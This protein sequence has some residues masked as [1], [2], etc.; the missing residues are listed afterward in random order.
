MIS[1]SDQMLRAIGQLRRR[2]NDTNE[3]SPTFSDEQ[4]YGYI[5][6]AVDHLELTSF[7]KGRAVEDG[8]FVSGTSLLPVTVPRPEQFLY[9]LQAAILVTMGIKSKADRDNFS[10]R[11]PN[12]SVDTSRQSSDHA[13]TIRS[14]Q[15][16]LNTRL[17]NMSS[18]TFSGARFSGDEA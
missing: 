8:D 7:K 11:K 10:L 6:D 12:L 2:I 16:E 17:F 13:E 9:V 14:L 3:T 18:T 1:Y 4:L 5:S 15:D